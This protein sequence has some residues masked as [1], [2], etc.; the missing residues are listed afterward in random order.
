MLL[1]SSP[2]SLLPFPPISP[3]FI[4]LS[5]TG[6][7]HGDLTTSNVL[8]RDGNP[9]QIVLIDFGLCSQMK[10]YYLLLYLLLFLLL[11]LF[12]ISPF[13]IFPSIYFRSQ[14]KRKESICMYW[15]GQLHPLIMIVNNYSNPYWRDM[16]RVEERELRSDMMAYGS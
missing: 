6:V 9:Q 13:L 14:Q 15:K 1:V 11:F 2:F 3:I 7:V 12:L 4:I 5:I 8:L 10:V 16:R